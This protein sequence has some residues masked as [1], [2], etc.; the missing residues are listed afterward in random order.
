[1]ACERPGVGFRQADGAARQ[2]GKTFYMAVQGGEVTA[3]A[4]RAVGKHPLPISPS[5]DWFALFQLCQPGR[6]GETERE[7]ADAP[8]ASRPAP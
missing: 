6:I 3:E 8:S 1:M 4:A 7:L 2:L 5:R